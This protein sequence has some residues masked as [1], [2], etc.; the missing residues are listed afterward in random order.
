MNEKIVL[1]NVSKLLSGWLKR[2]GRSMSRV[3]VE[4]GHSTNYLGLALGGGNPR[5]ELLIRLSNLTGINLLDMYM[6]LLSPELRATAGDRELRREIEVLR[7]ELV[8]TQAELEATKAERD[9]YWEVI[10]RR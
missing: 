4:M 6:E 3:S 2:E 5:V 8:A 7:T 1:P 9:K 10:A